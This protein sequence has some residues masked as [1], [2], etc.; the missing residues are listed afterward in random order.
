MGNVRLSYFKNAG[1]SAEVLEENNFY[2]F[3]LKH[4][5][6]NQMAGNLSY[7]YEYNGKELQKETGWSDFGARMYMA[8]I[9]RWGVVDPLAEST[10]RVNPYNYALNNPV[11]FIDPDGRKAM[12]SVEIDENSAGFGNGRGMLS[13]LE[14]GDSQSIMSFLGRDDE[15]M[16]S[17]IDG[18]GGGGG[19]AA[20][21]GK[22]QAYA[23]IMAYLAEPA[24]SEPDFS[25]FDFTQFATENNDC[26]KCPKLSNPIGKKVLDNKTSILGRL[27]ATLE[28]RTW[29]DGIIIYN[30]D[31]DGKILG[32]KP[33]TGDA[34][35][36]SA[37]SFK[38]TQLHGFYIRARTLFSNGTFEKTVQGLASLK[39]GTSLIKLI[40]SFESEAAAA[41]AKQIIIRGIDIVETRLIQDVG[42]AKRMRYTV[43]TTTKNSIKIYK[44]L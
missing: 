2:P 11:M 9:G 7:N 41:G 15:F 3:G 19:S 42:F 18:L 29:E 17:R 40:K 21:F 30:V 36:G 31:A 44:K 22:T 12:V 26:P 8:D 6:Y 32:I 25:K 16:K 37:G 14:R 33:Y 13:Y 27:W 24:S 39:E 38:V 5:G 1:G 4:E 43:E 28:L 34:P 10:I 23:D 20:T 35:I